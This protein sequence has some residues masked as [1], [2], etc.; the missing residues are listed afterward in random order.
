MHMDTFTYIHTCI[1]VVP[2]FPNVAEEAQST[3]VQRSWIERKLQLNNHTGQPAR[4]RIS[5]I[6]NEF[7]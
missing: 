7:L 5:S 3:L 1:R 6:F 4:D 2:A